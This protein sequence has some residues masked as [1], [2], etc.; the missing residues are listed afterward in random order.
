MEHQRKGI[1]ITNGIFAAKTALRAFLLGKRGIAWLL[2]RR[3]KADTV[4]K[5]ARERRVHLAKRG[6]TAQKR[7]LLPGKR[8]LLGRIG[9]AVWKKYF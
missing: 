4:P 8:A 1:S 3:A 9:L 6:R 5:A 7:R 2:R